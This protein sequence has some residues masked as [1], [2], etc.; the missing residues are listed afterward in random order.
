MDSKLLAN[1]VLLGIFLYAATGNL[2]AWWLS[3][4]KWLPL[5]KPLLMPV[6]A[7]YYVMNAPQIHWILVIALFFAFLGDVFLIW[8][9]K[10]WLF[11]G[12]LLSFAIMQIL[13]IVFIT[14]YQITIVNWSMVVS[15]AALGFMAIGGMIFF[16]LYKYLGSMKIPVV[17]YILLVVSVGFLCFINMTGNFN[18]Y[19]LFQF[20]G[21]MF[22]MVSDTILAFIS[23]RKPFPYAN[24][25]LMAMYINAQLFLFAGFINV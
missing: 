2:L 15:L 1:I 14:V 8:P 17:V 10:R 12:G 11:T 6:L 7:I 24:L 13:Y 9:E 16:M 20:I 21:A 25:L 4:L 19:Y 18:K 3:K 23:F 5:T 22:F